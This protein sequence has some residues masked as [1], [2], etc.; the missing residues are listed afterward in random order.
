MKSQPGLV[1]SPTEHYVFSFYW[2]AS[3]SYAPRACTFS[4]TLGDLDASPRALN[5]AA[6]PYEYQEYSLAFTGVEDLNFVSIW[7]GC[8]GN[9]VDFYFDDF[10]VAVDCNQPAADPGQG[11]TTL[12]GGNGGDGDGDGDGGSDWEAGTIIDPQDD[13]ICGDNIYAGDGSESVNP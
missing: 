13:E 11:G 2:A 4:I 1:T 6:T 3:S 8:G 10:K 5:M 9:E 7:M 12:P